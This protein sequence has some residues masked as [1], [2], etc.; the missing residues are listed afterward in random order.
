MSKGTV[1]LYP[2]ST[3]DNMQAGIIYEKSTEILTREI[4]VSA[5]EFKN[6]DGKRIVSTLPYTIIW[7]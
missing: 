6:K 7:D 5:I 2:P 4:P 1:Y 3:P